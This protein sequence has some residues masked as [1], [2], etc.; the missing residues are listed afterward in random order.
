MPKRRA[1][2]RDRMRQETPDVIGGPASGRS[3]SAAAAALSGFEHRHLES[4]HALPHLRVPT[5]TTDSLGPAVVIAASGK[6]A[7]RIRH[8]GADCEV[9]GRNRSPRIQGRLRS[10]KG[11]QGQ[12]IRS[13]CSTW[14]RRTKERI[15]TSGSIAPEPF[16]CGWFG[17]VL[18]GRERCGRCCSSPGPA[19]AARP[20]SASRCPIRF[21]P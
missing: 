16:T 2:H 8:C 12:E 11:L 18:F 21:A 19:R 7:P 4:A 20:R 6:A 15:I 17:S 10:L 1:Q 5:R 9:A 14:H 13:G 3:Q